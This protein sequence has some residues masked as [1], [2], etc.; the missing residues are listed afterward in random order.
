MQELQKALTS[1]QPQLTL[2][3]DHACVTIGRLLPAREPAASPFLYAMVSLWPWK[4]SF[5]L[6]PLAFP[7][8]QK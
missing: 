1:Q 4:A 8:P 2:T 5:L 6:L 3:H 7:E